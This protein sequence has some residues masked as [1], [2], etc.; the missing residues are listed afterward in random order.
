[1]LRSI[2]YISEMAGD[3]SEECLDQLTVLSCSHNLSADVTGMM[4][5]FSNRFIQVLEGP[6]ARV[7]ELYGRIR[8][9]PRHRHVVTVQD[10]P[11]TRRVYGD[12][13]MRRFKN[14]DLGESERA[15]IFRA[16]HSFEP[17]T[18]IGPKPWPP[19]GAMA[20]SM[21]RIMARAIP[22]RLPGEEFEALSRLLYAAEILLLRDVEV[23]EACFEAV[24]AD[25][26]VSLRLARRFFPTIDDLVGACVRRILALEH[27][28][29]LTRLISHRFENADELARCLTDFVIRNNDR[30]KVSRTFA[31][32]FA[33]HGAT[34]TSE[35][36]CLIGAAVQ[37]SERRQGW[38]A[39]GIELA[40]AIAVTEAAARIVAR[41]DASVLASE[42]TFARLFGI[43]RASLVETG[44][45]SEVVEAGR[46]R[47]APPSPARTN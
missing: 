18:L 33:L 24:A 34:F 37:R 44:A 36:S 11:I 38:I 25:A 28:A 10:G 4:Y 46:R 9:D 30:S 8:L 3:F 15:I 21:D 19:E 43:C 5:C 6:G 41:H 47:P 42:A 27:Q 17:R 31:A 2:A 7:G 13:A 1:M 23:T 14:E 39:S 20:G 16:L 29:L 26:K 45:S 12:F 22:T 40:M 32:C 35:M